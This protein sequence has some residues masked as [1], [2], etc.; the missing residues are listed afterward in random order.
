MRRNREEKKKF[1]VTYKANKESKGKLL[2]KEERNQV[3]N[4]LF[5]FRA[6]NGVNES[7]VMQLFI[8]LFFKIRKK[9]K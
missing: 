3:N 4:K 8:V 6:K 2:N 7:N 5:S 9:I 1:L